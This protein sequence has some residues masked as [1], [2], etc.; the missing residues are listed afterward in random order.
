M[1]ATII[2][3]YRSSNTWVPGQP[4]NQP[5]PTEF[6]KYNQSSLLVITQWNNDMMTVASQTLDCTVIYTV[7]MFWMTSADLTLTP[8]GC[9]N[10]DTARFVCCNSGELSTG[11]LGWIIQIVS[12]GCMPTW[13]SCRRTLC[14]SSSSRGSCQNSSTSTE[15]MP[16]TRQM[17]TR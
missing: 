15:P 17:I 1:A 5:S 9:H 11:V 10:T 7:D 3:K 13:S 4:V 14:T 12:A 6:L 2:K 16:T 8:T